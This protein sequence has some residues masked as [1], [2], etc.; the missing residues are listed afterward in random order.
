MKLYDIENCIFEGNII[1]N[2][3]EGQQYKTKKHV[4]F[5]R[6]FDDKR[7]KRSIQKFYNTGKY[8]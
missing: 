8:F 2:N 6:L 1:I 4:L 5:L 7:P 3:K